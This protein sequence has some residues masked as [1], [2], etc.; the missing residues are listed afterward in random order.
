L[1]LFPKTKNDRGVAGK[2]FEY[3]ATGV[4]ILALGPKD[5]DSAAIL[6]ETKAGRIFERNNKEG[7]LKFLY[8]AKEEIVIVRNKSVEKFSRRRL[9][10]TLINLINE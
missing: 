1:Y 3:L 9:T 5:G 7:V 2:L 4:P 10:E 8:D 6:E